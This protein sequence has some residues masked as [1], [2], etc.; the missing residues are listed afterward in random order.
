MIAW[1][2]VS[3]LSAGMAALIITIGSL[4]MTNKPKRPA[5]MNKLAKS[6]VDIATGES[7][8]ILFSDKQLQTSKAGK[9]GGKARAKTLTPQE[10]S[11]IAQLAANARWKKKN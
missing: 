6:I 1:F 3:W 11:E 10:R 5:D 2:A 7:E 8:E 9:K 4:P